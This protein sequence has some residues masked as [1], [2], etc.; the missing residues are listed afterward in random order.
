MNMANLRGSGS[1][2]IGRAILLELAT[3]KFPA[4]PCEAW[5][6]DHWERVL[7]GPGLCVHPSKGGMFNKLLIDNLYTRRGADQTKCIISFGDT[8]QI[9][10]RVPHIL[11]VQQAYLAYPPGEW[12]FPLSRKF[13]WKIALMTAYFQCML[14]TIHLITVQSEDMKNR[15]SARWKFPI[16]RI[17]VIP[18]TVNIKLLQQEI[19]SAKKQPYICY[20][21]DA[22]PHKNHI[23]LAKV[24]RIL[25]EWG[26]YLR[27]ILTVT[28]AE[29]PEMVAVAKELGVIESFDFM[30]KITQKICATLYRGALVH[31]MPS[32]LESFG[33][34]YYEAMGLECPSVVADRDFA[35]EACGTGAL[36]ANPDCAE[37]FAEQIR[38]L[39][40]SAEVY[41]EKQMAGKKRYEEWYRPWGR[42]TEEY[43]A[44]TDRI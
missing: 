27:C 4:Y 42:V 41:R 12:D 21:A 7:T 26:I 10:C 13:R 8:G 38:L 37:D 16:E 34:P 35:R 2:S 24:M 6:P 19:F 15:L 22:Y 36:Y 39:M 11:M 30:G 32:K 43:L 1:G 29:V 3:G 44:L 20:I 40:C 33:L 25:K 17:E 31:V 5:V 14:P 23:L 18:S 28:A 9:V